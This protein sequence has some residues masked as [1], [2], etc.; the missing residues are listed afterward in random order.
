VNFRKQKPTIKPI[1][2]VIFSIGMMI[3]SLIG[4]QRINKPTIH[5]ATKEEKTK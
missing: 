4:N 1:V 2:V 3:F 5:K